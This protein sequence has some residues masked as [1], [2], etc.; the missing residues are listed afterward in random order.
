MSAIKASVALCTYNGERYLKEQLESFGRQSH[1]PF[2]LV[3]GDDASSDQTLE[4]IESFAR[5]APF[6]V[7]IFHRDRVGYRANFVQ[8]AAACAGDVVF[9][10]D[11][12]DVWVDEKMARICRAFAENPDAQLYYHNATVVAADGEGTGL[13]LDGA[14]QRMRVGQQPMP[15]WHFTLGFTQAFRRELLDYQ[16]LWPLS[17]DHMTD[18]VM[19]HDQW[20]MFLAALLD[21]VVFIDEPLVRHRQH[22]TNT[23][24]VQAVSRW[25]KVLSRLSHDP[26][27]DRLAETAARQRASVAKDIA[28]RSAFRRARLEGI[29]R[30]YNELADRHARRYLAYTAPSLTQRARCFLAAVSQHDYRGRPWGLEPKAIPRDALRGVIAGGEG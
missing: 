20:Y 27:W 14:E 7:R 3:V 12:D 30:G 16:A 6:P 2:E 25:R 17:R 15:V 5:T 10:S 19:A 11:Q 13:L 18:A 24:G 8:T 9:F 23:Y 4:I 26:E 21:G 28:S 29:A 1:L 22:D